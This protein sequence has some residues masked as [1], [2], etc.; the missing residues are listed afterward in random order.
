[1][2]TGPV[3]DVLAGLMAQTTR[4]VNLRSVGVRERALRG[5]AS[6]VAHCH[7]VEAAAPCQGSKS[8]RGPVL[9]DQRLLRGVDHDRWLRDGRWGTIRR[10]FGLRLVNNRRWISRTRLF[11]KA[12]LQTLKPQDEIGFR[13]SVP[14]WLLHPHRRH[15]PQRKLE[16]L[17]NPKSM[18]GRVGSQ[19]AVAAD[20][21]DTPLL[22]SHRI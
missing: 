15:R 6:R 18:Q 8:V 13:D 3:A 21:A 22:H 20:E 19:L 10:A 4:Q 14:P 2:P 7:V 16:R 9:V 5:D 12:A 17:V 11:G 1:D